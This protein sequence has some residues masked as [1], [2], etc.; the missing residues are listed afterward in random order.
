VSDFPNAFA[1]R[2]GLAVLHKNAALYKLQLGNWEEAVRG[3]EKS[4][5]LGSGGDSYVWFLLAEAHWQLGEEPG[6][7]PEDRTRHKTEARHWYD[8][9]VEWMEEN[10]PQDEVLRRYRTSAEKVIGQ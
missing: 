1:N 2:R 5:S 4:M 3:F 7:S 6:A 9:A 10:K 8:K